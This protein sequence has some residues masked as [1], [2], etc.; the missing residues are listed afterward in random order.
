MIPADVLELVPRRTEVYTPRRFPVNAERAK[1]ELLDI[2]LRGLRARR[3][4]LRLKQGDPYLY[5]RGAEEYAFFHIHDYHPIV[6]LDIIS[7]LSRPLFASI[8]KTQQAVADQV[9]ICTG[10]GRL[11]VAPDTPGYMKCHMAVFLIALHRVSV[12]VELLFAAGNK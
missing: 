9:L 4:L 5:G 12:L 3:N 1:E 8:I 10:T 2:G 11:G 7:A 6:L